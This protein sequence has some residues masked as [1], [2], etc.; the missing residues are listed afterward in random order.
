M[1]GRNRLGFTLVELLVVIAIIGILIALLL[2]AVQAAREAARR[3]R[4]SNNLKQ[5]ALGLHNYHD[6]HRIFPWGG[7]GDNDYRWTSAPPS[8]GHCIYNWRGFILPFIEQQTLY[9]Q[10]AAEMTAAGAPIMMPYGADANVDPFMTAYQNMTAQTT[11][12]DA[13]QCPSDPYSGRKDAGSGAGWSP[14]PSAGAVTSYWGS[15]GPEAQYTYLPGLCG[16][17]PGCTVYNSPHFCASGVIGGGVG[18]FSLR[19]ECTRIRDVLDGTSNTLALGEEKIGDPEGVGM[20]GFRQWVDPF[21]V[22]STIKGINNTG[23][24]AAWGYYA[25]G[26]GSFHPGGAQFAL[27]DGSVRFISE[28]IDIITFCALGTKSKR[29]VVGDF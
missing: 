14:A 4:C 5:M 22:S 29:E 21:A 18:L 7:S 26:F 1:S 3:S 11:V 20:W 17:T 6:A 19:A 10:M 15:A 16:I 28:T 8:T 2:P 25:Q 9:D 13:F 24:P 27:A 23:D 12:V